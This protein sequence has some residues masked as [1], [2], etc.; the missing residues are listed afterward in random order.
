MCRTVIFPVVLYGFETWLF[1]LGNGHKWRV[2]RNRIL[3]NLFGP[4][5]EEATANRRQMNGE[6]MFDLYSS[7]NRGQWDGKACST[8]GWKRNVYRISVGKL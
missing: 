4:R 3:M 6:E 2:I 7:P 8:T 5:R 1:T